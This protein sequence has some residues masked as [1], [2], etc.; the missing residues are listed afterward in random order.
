VK[1]FLA[2]NLLRAARQLVPCQSFV[3]FDR[4]LDRYGE[5]CQHQ[6]KSPRDR[7]KV[8]SV[9]HDVT[10]ARMQRVTSL[11]SELRVNPKYH[12]YNPKCHP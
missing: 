2:V 8:H 3:Q 12:S 5:S 9:N 4:Y 6:Q 7:A 1:F 11:T 10:S